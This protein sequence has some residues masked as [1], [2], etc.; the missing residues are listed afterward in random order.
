M[1]AGKPF[2]AGTRIGVQ[3]VI[4][5]LHR[6]YSTEQILEQYPHLQR[7]DVR[8]CLSYMGGAVR[9]DRSEES[10]DDG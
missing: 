10:R 1:L 5:L 9:T 8:A 3:L 6:G 4:D 7:D 2:I